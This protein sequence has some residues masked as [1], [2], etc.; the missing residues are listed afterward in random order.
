M[1]R[2]VMV[3]VL[4]SGMSLLSVAT[5][6]GAFVDPFDYSA[7]DLASV[8]GGAW[9]GLASGLN[10]MTT[11]TGST[12][13]PNV[14]LP[15]HTGVPHVDVGRAF[16][17]SDGKQ[18]DMRLSA[19]S[20]TTPSGGDDLQMRITNNTGAYVAA[21]NPNL[22]YQVGIADGNF[23]F[24]KGI[25]TGAGPENTAGSV[26]AGNWYEFRILY[27]VLAGVDDE[28]QIDY[29][30]LTNAPGSWVN[31]VAANTIVENPLSTIGDNN[32]VIRTRDL[33]SRGLVA[34]DAQVVVPEPSS[35]ALCLM[36]LLGMAAT[37][38]WRRRRQ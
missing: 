6:Y 15:D 26:T 37:R 30:D 28:I 13:G 18:L 5:G 11:P 9:V 3:G 35:L 14:V 24:Q 4:C 32:F 29:R 1:M 19:Y 22:V 36:A 38:T 10:V 12:S 7:G 8:S 25:P 2:L 33:G 17:A 16:T 23:G 27:D 21:S 31:L 34:D 20:T